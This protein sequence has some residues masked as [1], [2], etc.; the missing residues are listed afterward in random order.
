MNDRFLILRFWLWLAGR[1]TLVMAGAVACG[2]LSVV[3][4]FIAMIGLLALLTR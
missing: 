2:L 4:V 3:F 1:V